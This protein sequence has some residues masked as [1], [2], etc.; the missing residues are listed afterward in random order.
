MR[1]NDA[2]QLRAGREEKFHIQ[3]KLHKAKFR[4]TERNNP[5]CTMVKVVVQTSS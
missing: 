2:Q 1:S 5:T 3:L 4:E